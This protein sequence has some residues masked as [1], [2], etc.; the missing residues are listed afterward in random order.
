VMT[1][2]THAVQMHAIQD[3]GGRRSDCASG[4]GQ[5]RSNDSACGEGC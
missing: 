3:D 1:E 5:R 4:V 2:E